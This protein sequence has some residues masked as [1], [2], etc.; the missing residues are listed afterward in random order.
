MPRKYTRKPNVVPRATWSEE[1]LTNAMIMAKNGA[2]GVN[3]ASRYYNIPSRTLRRR[4]KSGD[5]KKRSLGKP[6]VLGFENEKKL[7]A[8]IKRLE[9][10][11]FAPSR[12]TTR[13]LAFE[14]AKKLGKEKGL[15]SEKS[16]ENKTAAGSHWLYSF[17]ERNPELSVRQ[18]EG[19]SL[20][21][22][23]GMCREE[24]GSFFDLLQE[25]LEKNDLMDKPSCIWNMDESGIQLNN[26]PGKVLAS[27]GSKDVH[28][29]TSAEKGENITV[30]ACNNAVGTFLPPVL[31][32][33]GIRKKP[34][35]L[36]GLPPGT[37]IYMNK[38][39]SYINS[40]LF[41]RWIKEHFLPRK[42]P[43]KAL[44][45]LDGH[46]SHCSVE[47]LEL[48]DQ[49]DVVVICL[50]SHTTQA[51]QP[52]DR[53]FF[54]PLKDYFKEA[55]QD[56][57][58]NNKERKID[59]MN[60]GKLIGEAWKK[61]STVANGVSGFMATGIYP[62]NRNVI[63]DHF[64]QM[65]DVA[66]NYTPEEV[67]N[68]TTLE[69]TVDNSAIESEQPAPE[70]NAEVYLNLENESSEI[71]QLLDVENLPENFFDDPENYILSPYITANLAATCVSNEIQNPATQIE[72][73]QSRVAERNKENQS[74][75]SEF[76]TDQIITPS[77]FLDQIAPIPSIPQR[78]FNK[79]KQSA[80]VLTSEEFLKKKKKCK[81][82]EQK[83]NLKEGTRKTKS[84]KNTKPKKGEEEL[85]HVKPT[86]STS[87]KNAN[88]KTDDNVNCTECLE[89]YLLTKNNADWIQCIDCS[90]WLH[91]TC[92]M[93]DDRCNTCGR[94]EIRKSLAKRNILS[95]CLGKK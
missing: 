25:T 73:I 4:M 39:S 14:F 48:A 88:Q 60:A 30:V 84:T 12:R 74:P 41:L 20:A 89:N 78:K 23:K 55:A 34:E 70:I 13:Q 17:L 76:H 85:D 24:V 65:S 40:D 32:M 79:R 93:Y 26:K 37:D 95:K 15:L 83:D 47:M 35:H 9:Q 51:L 46:T 56:F 58:F 61:A 82:G 63:P 45:I 8:H 33:K 16:K 6:P 11:G 42:G 43:G 3:Q 62:L 1:D 44:L 57:M 18:S 38:Q 31:I 5:T 7:V 36:L 66:R 67:Q 92:T 71:G 64:F 75:I 81:N 72:E 50:P 68:D 27:K 28:V 22:A 77:K 91:E 69:L 2:M 86:A 87:T 80:E 10:A 21:R 53:S 94:N 90:E 59:R 54:K 52:L 29:L 19:L 49:N